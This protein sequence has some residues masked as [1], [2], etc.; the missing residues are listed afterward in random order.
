[1]MSLGATLTLIRKDIEL[2]P[3][4]AYQAYH[5]KSVLPVSR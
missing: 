5:A 1:M 2:Y 3:P 4:C